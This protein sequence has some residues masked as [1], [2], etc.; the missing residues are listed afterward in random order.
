MPVSRGW[1]DAMITDCIV[2]DNT[3]SVF[4]NAEFIDIWNWW[5]SEYELQ[6]PMGVVEVGIG[7]GTLFS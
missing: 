5:H 2:W 3:G 1:L 4:T 6:P 7:S